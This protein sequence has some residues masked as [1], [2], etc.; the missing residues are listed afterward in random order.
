MAIELKRCCF[1]N[2]NSEFVMF[3]QSVFWSLMAPLDFLHIFE[4]FHKLSDI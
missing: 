3:D 2:L 4:H 1:T